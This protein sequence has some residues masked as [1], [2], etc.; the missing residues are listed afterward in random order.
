MNKIYQ[1][2]DR[3][4]FLKITVR[5]M[6]QMHQSMLENGILKYGKCGPFLMM[7]N[8]FTLLYLARKN[9]KQLHLRDNKGNFF[10]KYLSV[11]KYIQP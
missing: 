2:Y 1:N 5:H 8:W 3:M 11:L 9:P 4:Q 7:L 6:P 10:L